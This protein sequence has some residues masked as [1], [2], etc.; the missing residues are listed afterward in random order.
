MS[1]E[2]RTR[3][4]R[5]GLGLEEDVCRQC[6]CLEAMEK[7]KSDH[8]KHRWIAVCVAVGVLPVIGWSGRCGA[9]NTLTPEANTAALAVDSAGVRKPARLPQAETGFG[10]LM[11][12]SLSHTSRTGNIF[13][14]P[15]SLH[16]CLQ[17]AYN[18]AKG[19]TAGEMAKV[20]GLSA[21]DIQ[22][23]NKEYKTL[24]Q[25]VADPPLWLR[26]AI[27][28]QKQDDEAYEK[29]LKAA[30]AANTMP[31]VRR[32]QDEVSIDPPLQVKVANSIWADRGTKFVSPY[33]ADCKKYFRADL[34]TL[35]FDDRKSVSRSTSG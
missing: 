7:L 5:F 11:I 21:I 24:L 26:E 23:G 20:L 10:F 19:A 30:E 9:Q 16:S 33:V 8:A 12:N 32:W 2:P 34:R 13:I 29:A 3:P 14:S 31:P 6:R 15:F 4:L 35:D 25:A 28:K 1:A 27:E 18:G 17:M 22:Q